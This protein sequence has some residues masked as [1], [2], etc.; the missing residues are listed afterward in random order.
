MKTILVSGSSSGIG[1]EICLQASDLGL[2]VLAISRNIDPLK[3]ILNLNAHSVDITNESQ[4]EEYVKKIT[5]ENIKIDILINNAG[6]L[7]KDSFRDTSYESFK[8]TYDVNVFGLASLTRA[9]IPIINKDGQVINI[10][11]VGGLN[12][13]KKFPGLSA[14]ASSKGAVIT[15]TEVLAEEYR[16]KPRF[17]CLALGSVQTEMLKK[18]FP[19]YEAK[20]M[21]SDMAKQIL[22]F[23]LDESSLPNG[24]IIKLDKGNL[25]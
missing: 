14:Y 21:P 22:D 6:F 10:T 16:S 8:Q 12:A 18:A 17:N 3:G 7:I 19:G 4:I 15:L 1:L 20:V 5:S 24:E 13:S 2:N 9:L 11:S 25:E 23:A